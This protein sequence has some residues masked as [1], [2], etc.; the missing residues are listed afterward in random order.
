MDRILVFDQG[1][2]VEDGTHASLLS[3][4]GLY[5]QMWECQVGGFLP[6]APVG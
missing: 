2:I 1:I 5:A 4:K 3:K 6:E